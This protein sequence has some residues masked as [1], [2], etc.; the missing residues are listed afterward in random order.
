MVI[1]P[2]QNTFMAFTLVY[3]DNNMDKVRGVS[4]YFK[5]YILFP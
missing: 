2:Y 3:C 1:N 5:M 4:D